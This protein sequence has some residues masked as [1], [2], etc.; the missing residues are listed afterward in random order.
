MAEKRWFLYQAPEKVKILT[1]N[2]INSCVR[3]RKRDMG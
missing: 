2:A 1:C 3:L